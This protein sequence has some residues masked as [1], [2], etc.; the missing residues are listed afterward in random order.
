MITR[1]EESKGRNGTLADA[2]SAFVNAAGRLENSYSS[3]QSEVAQLRQELKTRDAQLASSLAENKRVRHALHCIVEALPCGVVVLDED[4]NVV[5]SNPEAYKL[6][7][8]PVGSLEQRQPAPALLQ[9]MVGAADSRNG[10]ES[11]QEFGIHG[12]AGKRWV[13]LS[14]R[15]IQV[16]GLVPDSSSSDGFVVIARDITAHKEVEQERERSRN[17]VALAEV[18]SVLAHEVRNPLGGLEL[19]SGLLA[20]ADLTEEAK[21]WVEN[22]RAG[23]RQMSATVN[24][25]LGMHTMGTV[26]LIP[27]RIGELLAG[28]IRFVQPMAQ[29]SEIQITFQDG[30]G[31]A[32]IA[33]DS[34]SFRQVVLNLACNAFKFTPPGGR[35]TVSAQ[36]TRRRGRNK[37]VIEFA[38]TGAGIAPENLHRVFEAGFSGGNSPGLGLAICKRIVEQHGGKIMVRS[39]LGEGATFSMEF[40]AL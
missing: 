20:D 30:T 9:K 12:A 32:Q 40:P 4:Q 19:I 23:V 16:P 15:R 29:Q 22:I 25:I 17:M 28:S 10:T 6:L 34:N 18:A 13:A 31:D 1:I 38:D 27:V 8:I 21:G 2:F 35:L 36:G 26:R 24:N 5:L 11:E 37:V 39:R 14:K 33:A 7:N 3:L